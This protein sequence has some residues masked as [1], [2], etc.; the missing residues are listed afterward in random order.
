MRQVA[1]GSEGLDG[2]PDVTVH[3]RTAGSAY[4]EEPRGVRACVTAKRR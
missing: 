2:V 1:K 4:L 3:Q